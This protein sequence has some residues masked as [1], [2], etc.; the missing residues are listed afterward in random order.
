[1]ECRVHTNQ[2]VEQY[3]D[4]TIEIGANAVLTVNDHAAK[5]TTSFSPSAWLRI[6]YASAAVVEMTADEHED[7]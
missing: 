7:F 2:G 3:L 6:E 1:M 4:A 5:Q